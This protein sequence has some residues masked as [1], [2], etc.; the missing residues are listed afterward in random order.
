MQKV[1][2]TTSNWWMEKVT[3]IW[4]ILRR[5]MM[6]FNHND[7]FLFSED[8][9]GQLQNCWRSLV[10]EKLVDKICLNK[11]YQNSQQE[12]NKKHHGIYFK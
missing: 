1:K 5:K 11:T 12:L 9:K 2:K 8:V 6:T 7:V 3:S 4:C 10:F